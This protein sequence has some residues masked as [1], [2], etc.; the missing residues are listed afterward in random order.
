MYLGRAHPGVMATVML[1]AGCSLLSNAAD[2]VWSTLSGED[3]A[4]SGSSLPISTAPSE[5]RMP[6]SAAE[7][8]D[9][10]D[11]R[12]LVI[13]RFYRPNVHYEEALYVA[14][15]RA[16]AR[17][18]DVV[19]DLVAVAPQLDDLAQMTLHSDA[20]KR[21]ADSVFRSLTSMGVPAERVSLS[22]TTNA[23]VQGDEILLYVR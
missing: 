6:P 7:P 23:G 4:K 12:P 1:L 3:T 14:V 11:R 9:A 15:S 16:L 21:N 20:S 22:A 8:A 18:S 17:R 2:P 13:I 19:F 5:P 10:G